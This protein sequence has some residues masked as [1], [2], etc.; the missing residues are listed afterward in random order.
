MQ[1]EH[2][3]LEHLNDKINVIK[4]KFRKGT[5]VGVVDV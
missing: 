2:W 1:V 4:E 5:R 3:S